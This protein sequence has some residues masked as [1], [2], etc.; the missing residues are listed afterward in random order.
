MECKSVFA[1]GFSQI[2]VRPGFERR[3]K[4]RRCWKCGSEED[5]DKIRNIGRGRGGCRE[6][7]RGEK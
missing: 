2:F 4:R 3:G 1:S 7:G 6:T 5:D